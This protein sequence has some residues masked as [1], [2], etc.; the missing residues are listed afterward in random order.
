MMRRLSTP[1]AA[2]ATALALGG[3]GAVDLPSAL[4]APPTIQAVGILADERIDDP[5]RTYILVDGRT[6]HIKTDATRVLFEGGLGHPF[7]L[8]SDASGP[9]V[10]VFA[11][12]RRSCLD[13]WPHRPGRGDGIERGRSSRSRG[14]WKQAAD[15]HST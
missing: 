3:C 7:V 6:F 1:I 10:A 12:Q 5:D 2:L 14:P 11:H 13:D 15:F 8:G 4:P 9:F